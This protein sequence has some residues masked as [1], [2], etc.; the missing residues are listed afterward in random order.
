[1]SKNILVLTGSSRENGNS[2]MLADA[3]I[4]GAQSKNHKIQKF[5]TAFK[6]IKGCIACDKCWSDATPC[7]IKDD[8]TELV[9]LLEEADV[10]AFAFPLYW[11]SFPAQIKAPI[12]RLYAYAVPQTQKKLKIKESL[13]FITAGDTDKFVLEGAIMSYQQI[14]EMLQWQNK[15]IVGAMEVSDK[16]DI[17]KTGFLTRAEELGKKI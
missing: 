5:A 8:F 11:Y 15:G 12:D 4:R 14:C 9:P 13:M 17:K 2:E 3:F 7:V 10:I 6:N 1:M 16:G